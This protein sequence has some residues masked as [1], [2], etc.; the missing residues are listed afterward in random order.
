MDNVYSM[1]EKVDKFMH[2][3]IL[4]KKKDYTIHG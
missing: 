1:K 4:N 2:M 3:P